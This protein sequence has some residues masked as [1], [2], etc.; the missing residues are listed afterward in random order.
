[1]D[2]SITNNLKKLLKDRPDSEL[3]QSVIRIIILF[4]LTSYFYYFRES[5][6]QFTHLF[7]ASSIAITIALI[8]FILTSLSAKISMPRR[9][10]AMFFDMGTLSYMIYLSDEIG[11][12]LIFI[13]LWITFG[14]GFRYGNKYL[15]ASALLSIIGFSIV[16]IYNEYWQ[17][18]KSLGYGVIFAIITL[19]LYVSFLISKLHTAV[20]EAKAANEAKSQFL[21][22]M[23]HEIRTP[24]NGVIGMS[25]LLSETQLSPKQKDYSSTVNAS[26]KTLLALINDILDISKIEA[27]KVTVETVDFD[28]HATVNSTARMLAPQA[29]SKG[30]SFNVHIS[31]NA[32][33]LLCGDEQHLKQIIINLISNAIKF[34]KEGFIDIYVSHIS[35]SNKKVKLRFEVVD[36]GIGIPEEEKS[37]LFDKF[38]QADE[39]TTRKFGGTGLGMAIAKQLVETMGGKIDF[40]SKSN[41]GSTFW[42]EMEFEQQEILS[43]EKNSLV[44][45]DDS[46]ILIVNPIK[47][48]HQSIEDHLSLWPISYDFADHVHHAI[49][50]IVSANNSN[51]P[52]NVILVFQKYLDTDPE[53]FI[54]QTKIQSTYKNHVFILINDEQLPLL[55]KSQLLRSGYSSIINTNP[56]RTTL[57]RVLHA[58]V[59]DINTTTFENHTQ[60]SDEKTPHELSTQGLK[61]LVGED[62]KTNQ[63]V[64][65]NILEYGKHSV[66]LADNGEVVLDTLENES[67]DLIILDMQMPVMGGI[68]AAKIFRFMYP[69]RIN[70][71]ILMLTANATTEAIDACREAKFDA[72]LTKPVEPEKLL[73]TVASLV[74]VKDTNTSTSENTKLKIVDINNPHNIPLIDTNS[75]DS[76]Y[77]MAKEN[78]YMKNLIDGYIRDTNINIEQLTI[79]AKNGEYQKMVDLIHTLDGSSRSIGA[80]RLSIIADKFSKLMQT[81]NQIITDENIKELKIIFEKT[82][83]ALNSYLEEQLSTRSKLSS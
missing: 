80:K 69:N 64:I 73:K 27:G 34:T 18:L 79:S 72:Y 21:A 17:G 9:V 29:E 62:N 54:H 55:T 28:L 41:E 70:I 12:P 22:N 57:F 74:E 48:K 58:A 44:H 37:K 30:L 65:K 71:P 40:T 63:K 10:A 83:I 81:K 59:T 26:A 52:Y 36:T 7:M 56:D 33:F 6:N 32:P 67:F 43:E 51:A 45:F 11:V 76:L 75:L 1:M 53:N 5:I 24:L 13:Y 46:R 66:T 82:R 31:P 23:S 19:S 49:D 68:E 15:L 60:I 4:L 8:F 78:N 61:I 42:F 3:E 38:T 35:S 20:N 25:A 2:K 16:M 50:M 14:N 77:L 39:S 47:G